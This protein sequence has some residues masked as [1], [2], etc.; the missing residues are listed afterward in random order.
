MTVLS[1]GAVACLDL[2][3][4]HYQFGGPDAGQPLDAGAH[5]A[6]DAQCGTGHCVDGYCCDGACAGTCQACNVPGYEGHCT[7][8]QPGALC[9]AA[10]CSGSMKTLAGR[11]DSDGGCLPGPTLSCAPFTCGTGTDCRTSCSS[12]GDCTGMPCVNGSCGK[13]PVGSSCADA[14][15]CNSGSCAQGVCCQM[16]CAGGCQSCAVPMSEGVC[17]NVPAGDDPLGQCMD[18]GAVSCGH[19]GTCDGLGGCRDYAVNTP[20]AAASCLGSTLTPTRTCNGTGT[21]LAPMPADCGGGFACDTATNTCKATCSGPA[22]CAA[23]AYCGGGTCHAMKKPGDPCTGDAECGAARCIGGI[24]CGQL[25]DIDLPV[26][27]VSGT[28]TLGGAALPGTSALTTPLQ[29]FL[30]SK[31]DGSVQPLFSI[32][33]G[34]ASTPYTRTIG[35]ESYAGLKIVPGTY[36]LVY[37]RADS[38]SLIGRQVFTAGSVDAIPLGRQVLKDV[39]LP[40]GPFTLDI[41]IPVATV[42]GTVTMAGAAL[43][44]TSTVYASALELLLRSKD[45]GSVTVVS[46]I[47]YTG[48]S[49]PY[50][51]PIG[52]DVYAGMKV[53]PG[54]YEVLYQRTY[55]DPP[56]TGP[57]VF[58]AVATDAIPFGR[59]VLKEVT[60]TPGPFALDIDVPVATLG[61]T[62]TM[63]GLA[64]PG[65]S[66]VY[67]SALQFFLRS[68]EDGALTQLWTISYSGASTPYPRPTGSETYAGVKVVPGTY[69]LLYQRAYSSTPAL[70]PQVFSAVSTDA[71]PLGRQVLKQ[72]VVPSGPSTV[73]IDVPVATVGGTVTMAGAALP[74]TSGLYGY[75]LQVFL[76]SGDGSLTLLWS[77]DYNAGSAPYA[78]A[79]GSESFAGMKVLPGTYDLVYQR[80]YSSTPA[81]GAQEFQPVSTDA[82]PLGR[83]VLK[84]VTVPAGPFTLNVDLPVATLGGKVTLAGA[85]LPG[86][87]S[88]NGSYPLQFLLRSKD[89]G[90][91]TQLWT[92]TYSGAS[93]PYPRPIGS[94]SYAGVVVVPGTYELVYQ[95]AYSNTPTLGAQLFTLDATDAI[96]LGRQVLK[97]V[98][99]PPGSST[100]DID[101]P[102]TTVNGTVTM[103]GAALPGTSALNA[104]YPLQFLLRSKSDGSVT[105]LWSITYSGAGSPYPR[106]IGSDMFSGLKLVSGAYELLYQRSYSTNELGSV[107][108]GVSSQDAVPLGRQVLSACVS[109]GCTGA[110]CTAPA[111]CSGPGTTCNSSSE[112]CSGSS[113]NSNGFCSV[114]PI[115]GATQDACSFDSDC[116]TG[117]YCYGSRRCAPNNCRI[118][119][120]ACSHDYECCSYNCYNGVCHT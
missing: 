71:I 61:G 107:S 46:S 66:T 118:N 26:S 24:C 103:S 89:D 8:E 82:I 70:G 109:V 95:R 64:L 16:A 23:G 80:E 96:P 27:T 97:D 20:C 5:C 67:G 90:S 55:S 111:D 74:G 63:A 85:A 37:Q 30:R 53:L 9:A 93:S 76:R 104:S 33:F 44:G 35:S 54:T 43:P 45:D 18:D 105:A 56:S 51:R 47:N 101:V 14:G 34:G 75:P 114:N 59:Q 32:S 62:V 12:D 83:Q 84:Q 4:S 38:I 1:V 11:C 119:S 6:A 116:C 113:C 78:R 112:C 15:D 98:T 40:A 120:H 50:P 25:G 68:S 94:D 52:S 41:D 31:T 81:L 108:A 117:S 87:S 7:A 60:V 57:Q 86:S 92:I 79:V 110:A 19:D 22:D 39:T 100:L 3:P 88:L 102:V 73:D 58:S 10:S 77:V 28:V 2:D 42:G 99:V 48:A 72:V 17:L 106:M 115:C 36:S 29:L 91:V 13:K 65:T 21:C 49:S 69:D